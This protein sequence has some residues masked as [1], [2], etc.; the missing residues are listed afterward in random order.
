MA[1][2]VL[3]VFIFVVALRGTPPTRKTYLV[4]AAAALVTSVW[5][6]FG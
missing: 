1:F 5:E 4:I 6:Y 3:V 2:S